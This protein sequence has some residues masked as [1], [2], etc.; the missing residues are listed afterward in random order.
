M[1]A[2]CKQFEL[3]VLCLDLY[4]GNYFQ[5]NNDTFSEIRVLYLQDKENDD[6]ELITCKNNQSQI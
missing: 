1:K 5:D 6:S 3:Y 2:K 4:T